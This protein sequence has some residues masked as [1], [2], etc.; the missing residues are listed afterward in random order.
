MKNGHYTKADIVELNTYKESKFVRVAVAELISGTKIWS[1]GLDVQII[2]P[3]GEKQMYMDFTKDKIP[4]VYAVVAEMVCKK[5]YGHGGYRPGAGR[6]KDESKAPKIACSFR[7]TAEEREKVKQ[8]INDM[9]AES[10][11]KK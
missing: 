10:G 7:L 11:E 1:N 6:K 8:F 5:A 3:S 4:A 9:R 2:E